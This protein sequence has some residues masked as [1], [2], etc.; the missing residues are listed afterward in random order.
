MLQSDIAQLAVV[1]EPQRLQ[2]REFP[3]WCDPLIAEF[4]GDD[5]ERIQS[6]DVSEMC[7]EG[8][9]VGINFA[10]VVRS[11]V[12]HRE[13]HELER[14]KESDVATSRLLQAVGG[15]VDLLDLAGRNLDGTQDGFD[16][17]ALLS[18]G[19]QR[20]GVALKGLF[21]ACICSGRDD[22]VEVTLGFDSGESGRNLSGERRS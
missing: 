21:Q 10:M 8:G 15:R 19:E 16:M 14:V 1:S 4:G 11:R 2:V 9:V 12:G 18:S 6:L 5:V 3:Q 20:G 13:V 17:R 22:G 7:E